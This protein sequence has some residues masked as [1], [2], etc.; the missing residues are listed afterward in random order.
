MDCTSQS[1][2]QDADQITAV[3]MLIF[4]LVL[5]GALARPAAIVIAEY[6]CELLYLLLPAFTVEYVGCNYGLSA[7]F[8][9]CHLASPFVV[10]QR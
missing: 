6:L 7:D 2:I 5:V 1:E 4:Q 9:F 8:T 3:A 10:D